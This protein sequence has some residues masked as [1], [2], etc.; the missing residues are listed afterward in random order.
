M[1]MLR[2]GEADAMFLYADQAY[3]Y[4]CDETGKTHSGAEPTWDCSLWAN[5]G[6]EYAYVQTGQFGHAINGTTLAIS[7][8]GS[9]L[10]DLLNP[11]IQ[12]FMKTKEYFDVCVKHDMVPSCYKNEFFPTEEGKA[13]PYLQATRE[14]TTGCSDGYCSCP[15]V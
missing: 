11:C 1:K 14:H 6:V 3:N 2:D 9:G 12:K 5:F 8:K 4:E 15:A 7:K 13:K 10:A